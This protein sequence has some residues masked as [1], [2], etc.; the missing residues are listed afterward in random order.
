[1]AKRQLMKIRIGI[2]SILFLLAT[3]AFAQTCPVGEKDDH[4]TIHR[5]MQNF[6]RFFS[7]AEMTV[8]R[9][10]DPN[11]QVTANDLAISIDKLNLI[12]SC[13]EAVLQDP[14]GDLLPDQA[15]R[16]S[17]DERDE[18]ISDFVYFMED[19]RD[20]VSQF[21]D[22]FIQLQGEDPK[23]WDFKPLK[24]KDDELNEQI[25]HAHHHV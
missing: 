14:T 25:E 18:Y 24:E 13:A 19:F 1:M 9:G 21:R 6:G 2:L 5:V 22:L 20:N 12:I 7:V 4:L 17:R 16:L 15:S 10:M 8:L 3:S 23:S 11:D